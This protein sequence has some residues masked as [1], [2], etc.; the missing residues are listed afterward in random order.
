MQV[1]I[2]LAAAHILD[3]L[4]TSLGTA[5]M[6]ANPLL[7]VAWQSHGLWAVGLIKVAC[8]TATLLYHLAVI[9]WLPQLAKYAAWGLWIGTAVLAGVCVWNTWQVLR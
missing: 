9:R 2:W 5:H 7:R 3:L 6:E 1:H 8:W 4:T